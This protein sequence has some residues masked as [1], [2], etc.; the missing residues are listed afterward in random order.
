MIYDFARDGA[1][2]IVVSSDL[3]EVL[4]IT[5]RV[6]VMRQG[7][8]AGELMRAEATQESAPGLALPLSV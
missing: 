4:G 6:L 1:G 7:R 5:D 2:V 8:I 3:P